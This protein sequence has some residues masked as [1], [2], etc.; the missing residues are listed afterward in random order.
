[1]E[2]D[3]LLHGLTVRYVSTDV[4]GVHRMTMLLNGVRIGRTDLHIGQDCDKK[5][6]NY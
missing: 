2:L 4:V 6:Q 3:H 1:L 5:K